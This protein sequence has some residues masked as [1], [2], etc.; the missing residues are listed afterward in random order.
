MAEGNGRTWSPE[1]KSLGDTIVALAKT[2]AAELSE[3][4]EQVYKIKGGKGGAG[5]AVPPPTQQEEAP[6][7]PT[8]FHVVLEGVADPAKR[9]GVIKVVRE[10]TSLG[11]KEAKDL[12]E[13]APKRV[14]ENLP[15]AEAEAL[16]KKL[17]E[18]GGKAK[19]EP[20]T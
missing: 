14:K 19:L 11:L 20:A 12:V 7:A 1:V 13:A 16:Q 5:P 3:Y 18:G 17:E 4:L 6:P 2:K 9:V 10:I 15:K 8:E